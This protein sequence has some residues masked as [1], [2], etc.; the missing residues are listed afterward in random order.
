[1]LVVAER[2]APTFA[3]VGI[4]TADG[5]VHMGHLPGVGVELLTED[6]DLAEVALMLLHK[7]GALDEHAART[8]GWVV[9]TPLERLEHL[10]DG[11]HNARWR[12][13]LT[14]RRLGLGGKVLQAVFVDT[15]EEVDALAMGVHVHVVEN[16]HHLAQTDLV[17]F[18]TGIVIGHHLL[19]LGI[20]LPN[21]FECMVDDLSNLR[22]V[23]HAGNVLPPGIL[24]HPKNVFGSIFVAVFLK[25]FTLFHKLVVTLI[26]AVADIF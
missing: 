2:V 21:L 17:D 14:A 3:Q 22:A 10:D 18:R 8:A 23:R 1:M 20:L 9:D 11:T 6:V 15:A 13:E 26:E 5:K 7:L 12:I 4:Q 19:E 25:A 16:L 24:R